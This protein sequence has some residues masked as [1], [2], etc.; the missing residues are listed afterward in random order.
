MDL[1]SIDFLAPSTA[2][3]LETFGKLNALFGTA[4]A[5]SELLRLEEEGRIAHEF[6]TATPGRYVN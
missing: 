6:A 2:Y 5:Q 4:A 3:E 1:N